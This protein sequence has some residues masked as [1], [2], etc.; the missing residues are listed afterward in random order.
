MLSLVLPVASAVAADTG[1]GST[2]YERHCVVCHGRQG[3]PVWP[4]APDFR[5]PGSL[6]KADTQLLALLRQGRGVMPGYLGLLK[7][8]E[9]SDL[10]A[11]VRTLSR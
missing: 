9:M 8:R 4:G 6:M 10:L 11:Y 1:R 2:V 5:R 7:D 3:E